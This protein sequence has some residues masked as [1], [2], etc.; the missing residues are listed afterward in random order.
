MLHCDIMVRFAVTRNTI[1]EIV[2]DPDQKWLD[3]N[4]ATVRS[5]CDQRRATYEITEGFI[6]FDCE[7][8]A[9]LFL[10]RFSDC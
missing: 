10:L 2:I 1:G 9:A 6:I 7:R 3:D 8:E 4:L 5:W